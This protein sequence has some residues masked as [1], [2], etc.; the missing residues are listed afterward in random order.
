MDST[1]AGYEENKLRTTSHHEYKYNDKRRLQRISPYTQKLLRTETK[2]IQV[3]TAN[4]SGSPL[5]GEGMGGE[6]DHLSVNTDN[7]GERK[8]WQSI[9]SNQEI[10]TTEI[11]TEDYLHSGG[12]IGQRHLS[13]TASKH[14]DPVIFDSAVPIDGET[15]TSLDESQKL[16]SFR[17]VQKTQQANHLP[18]RLPP[19]QRNEDVY[20]HSE[21]QIISAALFMQDNCPQ[22][23]PDSGS[24]PH[25]EKQILGYF[26][27]LR[28]LKDVPSDSASTLTTE[29]IGSYAFTRRLLDRQNQIKAEWRT[30]DISCKECNLRKSK[31]LE[32][33]TS[34]DTK[35]AI[36][37]WRSDSRFKIDHLFNN[38]LSSLASLSEPTFSLTAYSPKWIKRFSSNLKL[39]RIQP[40]TTNIIGFQINRLPE[41]YCKIELCNAGIIPECLNLLETRHFLLQKNRNRL[42]PSSPSSRFPGSI[43]IYSYCFWIRLEPWIESLFEN[44]DDRRIESIGRVSDCR[45][46]LTKRVRRNP[47]GFIEIMVNI[48]APSASALQKC[49]KLFDDKF[50]KFYASAGLLLEHDQLSN[51]SNFHSFMPTYERNLIKGPPNGHINESKNSSVYKNSCSTLCSNHKLCYSTTCS[52]NY[53]GKRTGN[54]TSQI[55]SRHCRQYYFKCR[56]VINSNANNQTIKFLPLP[57]PESLDNFTQERISNMW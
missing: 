36:K 35:E 11:L 54:S 32:T 15:A 31:Y 29:H 50:P 19:N 42:F 20:H 48:L 51:L 53:E 13:Y 10:M 5:A 12:N 37:D 26:K 56:E 3:A 46:C 17:F 49:C 9:R 43:N 41:D 45:I 40:D 55:L 28:K 8:T 2:M 14:P 23:S 16:K 39:F 1:T 52:R 27:N 44:H 22:Y 6:S 57:H 24:I 21:K 4:S 47:I 33:T 30:V 34:A 18:K 7:Y 38:E 25:Q